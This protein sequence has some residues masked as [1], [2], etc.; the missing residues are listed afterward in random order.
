MLV[1]SFRQIV[2]NRGVNYS[3]NS[4]RATGVEGKFCSFGFAKGWH[5]A[6]GKP[7]GAKCGQDEY[8]F[9]KCAVANIFKTIWLAYKCRQVGLFRVNAKLFTVSLS[10]AYLVKMSK[11][12]G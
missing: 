2:L 3:T 4:R 1:C 11:F 10:F 9:F 8:C 6:S 12:D 7:K 5:C